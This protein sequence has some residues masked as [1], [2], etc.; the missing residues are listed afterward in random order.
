MSTPRLVFTGQ[1]SQDSQDKDTEGQKEKRNKINFCSDIIS[2]MNL[3][4]NNYFV[5]FFLLSFCI[6]VLICLQCLMA[7][8]TSAPEGA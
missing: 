1:D 4:P 6:L 3:N 8:A 5:S 2:M 7:T